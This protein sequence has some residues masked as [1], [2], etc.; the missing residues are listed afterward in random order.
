MVKSRIYF[1]LFSILIINVTWSIIPYKEEQPIFIFV[2][3]QHEVSNEKNNLF[4][5]FCPRALGH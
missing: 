3:M 2:T 5:N 4:N 1:N